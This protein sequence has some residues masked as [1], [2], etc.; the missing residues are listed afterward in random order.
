LKVDSRPAIHAQGVMLRRECYEKYG[1]YD[2]ILRSKADKEMWVRLRDTLKLDIGSIKDV[3][4]FY[5][6]HDESMMAYRRKNKDYQKQVV[7]IF[8]RQVILRQKGINEQN[9]KFLP[10]GKA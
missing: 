2:E 7:D 10:R 3:V 9:T 5:R 6:R 8:E 1:L 4:A